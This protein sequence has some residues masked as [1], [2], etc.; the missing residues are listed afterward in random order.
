[1]SSTDRA[2]P[3]HKR[4]V[5]PAKERLPLP[6]LLALSTAVFL[7][8]LTEVLPAGLLPAMSA[9]LG[10][11]ESA[12]GQTV[13]VFA[14]AIALTALPLTSA[15]A[16]WPRRR[17]LLTAMAGFGLAN[18]VTALSSSYP[19]TLA[20]RAVAGV[21]AGLAWALLAGYARSLV[22]ARL[23]GRAVAV[24]LAGIPVALAV[25]VPAGTYLGLTADWR[26]AFLAM[27]ALTVVLLC[28]ITLV[29]P[30][31]PGRPAGARTPVARVLAIPGVLPVLAV[32]LLFVLAH[33]LCY[34]YFAPY[35]H[36]VG[37]GGSTD[38]VLLVFGLASLLSIWLVGALIHRRLRALTLVATLL[39][40]GAAALLAVPAH[41]AAL[42]YAAAALWGLGWGGTP[43]LLQTAAGDAGDGAEEEDGTGG[44]AAEATQ[45]WL[46]TL[47]NVATAGGGL[48]GGLLLD[49]LGTGA[50]P[51]SV[52]A[53][54]VPALAV[55]AGA[56]RHGF[57]VRARTAPDAGRP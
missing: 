1:M 21:A 27:T 35:L 12:T 42:V 34:T 20:A 6:A 13:T 41:S 19:L 46:V 24:A 9:D 30:D 29:V 52:L 28:W 23:H 7:T 37:M 18:T 56:R 3:V 45:A 49:G 25:G 32:T 48:A 4:P 22:P 2:I 33:T 39:V 8:C 17:L 55:A 10:V 31:R 38:R 26:T 36:H 47:W 44:G 51:W 5:E 54:L 53:F 43:T 14:L 11:S 40:A 50:L 15:T 16:P 57:P